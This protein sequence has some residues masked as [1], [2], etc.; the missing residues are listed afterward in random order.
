MTSHESA[1]AWERE[2]AD[3]HQQLLERDQRVR[4]LEFENAALRRHLE[5]V[6]QT[7]AWRLAER[8]R[9]VRSH[10]ARRRA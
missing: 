10:V 1:N 8:Y 2:L 3:A 5:S 6:L 9:T 4:H 7:K